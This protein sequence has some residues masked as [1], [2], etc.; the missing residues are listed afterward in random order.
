MRK[1][2]TFTSGDVIRFYCENLT[3]KEKD[4]VQFFFY[5]ILPLTQGIEV[6]LDVIERNVK[7]PRIKL[8]VKSIQILWKAVLAI[9]PEALSFAIPES[10]K[11]EVIKCLE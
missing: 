7:D 3:E 9:A 4:D 6:L 1:D 5:I 11:K 8:V 2:L 10:I